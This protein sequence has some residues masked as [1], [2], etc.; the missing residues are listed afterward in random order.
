MFFYFC[1]QC[2][3]NVVTACNGASQIPSLSN[4]VEFCTQWLAIHC[5]RT[6]VDRAFQFLDPELQATVFSI[7]ENFISSTVDLQ[8]I[9]GHASVP[10]RTVIALL[11]KLDRATQTCPRELEWGKKIFEKLEALHLKCLQTMV[12]SFVDWMR[13]ETEKNIS[14]CD[15]IFGISGSVSSCVAFC[16][17]MKDSVTM[18]NVCE[19]LK[20]VTLLIQRSKF[21]EPKLAFSLSFSKEG[22]DALVN[23][24]SY[25]ESFIKSNYGWV[26][27]TQG[28][29]ALPVESRTRLQSGM[30]RKKKPVFVIITFFHSL[31]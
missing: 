27:K 7:A 10:S 22:Q 14:F 18:D 24:Q 30:V 25:L 21:F 31:F 28:F 23:L 8:A 1:I 4:L 13:E 3:T 16:E 26:C 2:I 6:W 5:D 29:L 12:D 15:F 19:I 20:S 9:P 11:S 17:H